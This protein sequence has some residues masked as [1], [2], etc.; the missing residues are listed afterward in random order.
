MTMKKCEVSTR[1]CYFIGSP[2]QDPITKYALS[3]PMNPLG[4]LANGYVLAG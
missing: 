1:H 3:N 2:I 4:G